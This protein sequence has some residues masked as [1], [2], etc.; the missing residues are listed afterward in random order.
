MPGGSQ[1]EDSTPLAKVGL[2]DEAH[3]GEDGADV[4]QAALH[5]DLR[6]CAPSRCHINA[7]QRHSCVRQRN[8][9]LHEAEK[10]R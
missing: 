9:A 8:G 10:S 5:R 1:G 4:I 2:L 3:G 6:L 7:D